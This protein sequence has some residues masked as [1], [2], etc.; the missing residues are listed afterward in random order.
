L[1]AKKVVSGDWAR[2]VITPSNTARMANLG[3]GSESGRESEIGL[4]M[5]RGRGRI[6]KVRIAPNRAC[7]E[8]RIVNA[9][10]PVVPA[11]TGPLLERDAQAGQQST[12][13]PAGG[14]L[15]PSFLRF[16]IDAVWNGA[17]VRFSDD[18]AIGPAPRFGDATAP[19]WFK[20]QG[21]RIDQNGLE[22][23][24]E[25]PWR[26]R[27]ADLN[28]H[29]LDAFRFVVLRNDPNITV[30]RVRVRVVD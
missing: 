18:A 12:W 6:V 29:Q 9:S 30:Q 23:G 3:I 26:D 21:A 14:A 28:N 24:S 5:R 11:N 15:F 10:P 25:S 7:F 2:A 20:L 27:A 8:T 16:E 17:S 1:A 22:P 4:A 13:Y 19:L